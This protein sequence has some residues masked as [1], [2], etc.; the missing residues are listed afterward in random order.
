MGVCTFMNKLWAVGGSDSWNCLGHAEI[1]DPTSDQWNFTSNLLT[2][3]R[4]CGL[5][6]FKGKLYCVGGSDG[7]H[8]LSSTEIYDEDTKS[9]VLGPNLTTPRANVSVIVVQGKLYA[10]GGFSG[11]AFLNTIE[12]LDPNTNEW[13][14]FVS[15]QNSEIERITEVLAK[16]NCFRPIKIA[17]GHENGS[18][19]LLK[20]TNGVCILKNGGD[21][22]DED[23]G[24]KSS[25]ISKNDKTNGVHKNGIDNHNGHQDGED[26][27]SKDS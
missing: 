27:I 15:Q 11:K 20:K 18:C 16:Q 8:S 25:I 24:K 7:T 19:D 9:W 23:D 12:Y 17:N 3:R 6:E 10:I 2:S 1:Y 26:L 14:T 21:D 5:A 4:G 13:T 22:E